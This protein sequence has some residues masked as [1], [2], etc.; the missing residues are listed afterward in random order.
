MAKAA[1]D[2]RIS[3]RKEKRIKLMLTKKMGG[4]NIVVSGM[5]VV[6]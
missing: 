4:K 3:G 5:I 6:L 1:M 2:K